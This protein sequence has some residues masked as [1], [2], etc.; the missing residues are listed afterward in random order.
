L[1]AL[2]D[3]HVVST[4]V[5]VNNA[6]ALFVL[7]VLTV[8]AAFINLGTLNL[9]I[10]MAIAIAKATLIILYFM[11]VRYTTNAIRVWVIAS[12]F[13]LAVLI[14]GTLHDYYT[15]HW[16]RI[17]NELPEG[18]PPALRESERAKRFTGVRP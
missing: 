12:F 2:N 4:K 13:G 14:G 10:A 9:A 17:A 18:I 15:R 7:F 16:P 6:I 3:H 11:H 1:A 8:G 5:Y